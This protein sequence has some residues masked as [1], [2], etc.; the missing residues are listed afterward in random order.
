MDTI[1]HITIGLGLGELAQIDP[2]VAGNPTLSHAVLLGTVIGSNLPDFDFV[3]LMK[4]KGSYFRN[5]RAFSHSILALPIWSIALSGVIYLFFPKASFLHLFL[6]TLLSVILHVFFDLFNVHGTQILLP[7]FKKWISF[8]SL[9]LVDPTLLLVHLLGFCLLPFFHPGT[10]FLIIYLFILFYVAF[11]TLSTIFVKEYLKGY[12]RNSTRIKLIPQSSPFKWGIIIETKEDFLFGHFSKGDL[13]IEHSLSKK[14]DYPELVSDSK[15]HP[16][17]ADFLSST[18]YAY[19]FV[20]ERKNGYLIYW[21]DL[22]FR[23]NKF[24]STLAILFIS[25]DLN[26]KNC[27]IGSLHSLKQYRKI[28]KKLKTRQLGNPEYVEKG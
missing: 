24:F 22:R 14:I 6:W 10:I 21:K 25:S 3:C 20:Y 12:F 9:P 16:S 27:F 26:V 17:I 11:R 4:G 28:I 19:P 7:F 15:N 18:H 13:L 2:L 5:H 23:S 1:S 8:D